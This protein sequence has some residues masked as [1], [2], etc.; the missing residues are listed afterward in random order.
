MP[1]RDLL[2]G[3][4]SP[5]TETDLLRY[6]NVF[7]PQQQKNHP[8]RVS[9]TSCVVAFSFLFCHYSISP[10]RVLLA[11][12]AVHF[13]IYLLPRVVIIISSRCHGVIFLC[14]G[15]SPKT[16][17]DLL[18]PANVFP[19]QQNNHPRRVSTTSSVAAFF[20][21]YCYCYSISSCRG[22][23]MPVVHPV[24]ISSP[25]LQPSLLAMPAWVSSRW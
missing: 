15:S 3:G 8:R 25:G 16:E 19:P 22:L 7:P 11:M 10:S 17:T 4:W 9:T 13:T 2:R 18:P 21:F 1:W 24:I 6:A 12:P 23:A 20:R 14:G 5:K